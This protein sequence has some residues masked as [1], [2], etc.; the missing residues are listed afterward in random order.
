MVR[1]LEFQLISVAEFHLL[2]DLEPGI[3][4]YL[5]K[6]LESSLPRRIVPLVFEGLFEI[7]GEVEFLKL[8]QF[9]FHESFFLGVRAAL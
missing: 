8:G 3:F 1:I 7:F 5:V 4:L 6:I 2:Y 9:L